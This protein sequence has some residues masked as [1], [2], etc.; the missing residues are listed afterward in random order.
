MTFQPISIPTNKLSKPN[1][2]EKVSLELGWL[3]V[4]DMNLKWQKQSEKKLF[5]TRLIEDT[6]FMTYAAA[7]HQGA[8]KTLWLHF[9]E[10]F[11]SSIFM[12]I[13]W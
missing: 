10:A 1:L 5:L 12:Y 6:E 7:S 4:P 2:L 9:W 13:P 8:F 3:E 11:M